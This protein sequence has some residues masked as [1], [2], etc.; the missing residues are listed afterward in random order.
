[1]SLTYDASQAIRE[2]SRA[3]GKLGQVIREVGAFELKP[4]GVV[5]VFENLVKAIIYQQ[6]SGR[7]ART[8]HERVKDLFPGKRIKPELVSGRSDE[9][10][11]GAGLSRNKLLAIRDLSEK[12]LDATVPAL[13]RLRKMDDEEIIQR[14]VQ[15]RGIGRWTVEMFL[16]FH[17]GR[18]DVMP[19]TDLGIRKGYM[20]LQGMGEMPKPKELRLHTEHWKPWRSVASWYLYRLVDLEF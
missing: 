6:L 3:D 11:R 12:T 8:I 7:A 9:E 16:M 13:V 15:V 20:L 5:N 1:M 17:L 19:A 18:P 14:L 4:R 10:L 2:L